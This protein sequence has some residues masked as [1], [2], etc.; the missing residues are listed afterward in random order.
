[1][2]SR[3]SALSPLSNGVDMAEDGSTPRARARDSLILEVTC[4]DRDTR[5]RAPRPRA[6]AASSLAA[7][8]ECPARAAH[9]QVTALLP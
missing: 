6:L 1:M 5:F 3:V 2:P 9:A 7:R 8:T 4:N